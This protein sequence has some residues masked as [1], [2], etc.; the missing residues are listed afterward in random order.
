[1]SWIYG[2][3][4]DA[5]GIKVYQYAWGKKV[6]FV[7]H[8]EGKEYKSE[9]YPLEWYT[10]GGSSYGPHKVW[11]RFG[12][13]KASRRLLIKAF[14]KD[15]CNH[16]NYNEVELF[17]AFNIKHEPYSDGSGGCEETHLEKWHNRSWTRKRR[18]DKVTTTLYNN[19]GLEIIEYLN[20][21]KV[22]DVRSM[23]FAVIYNGKICKSR[24]HKPKWKFFK[25]IPYLN[26]DQVPN[27]LKLQNGGEIKNFEVEV[28]YTDEKDEDCWD[29][30]SQNYIFHL[31]ADT[32]SPKLV[33]QKPKITT[34]RDNIIT[35]ML[36]EGAFDKKE[37]LVKKISST[38]PHKEVY[39]IYFDS[40]VYEIQNLE[41][42]RCYVG[43][44]RLSFVLDKK[45]KTLN[46]NLYVYGRR[47]D[48]SYSWEF[49]L[50]NR[51]IC[52]I[53]PTKQPTKP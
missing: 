15:F 9:D 39:E 6:N 1:M 32:E 11:F 14:F 41:N 17:Y 31:N 48:G 47:I 3:D 40:E 25:D 34:K 50:I 19:D 4:E 18:N 53:P 37:I 24:L 7:V 51:T 43:R 30:F 23:Q 42:Y 5:G 46:I 20:L 2:Y 29:R 33:A 16:N 38:K 8:Y 28:W 49:D 22:G 44:D 36:Y 52:F 45:K 27:N 35:K 21:D 26:I 12:F 13:S 10:Y